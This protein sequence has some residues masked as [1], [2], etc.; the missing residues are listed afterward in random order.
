MRHRPCKNIPATRPPLKLCWVFSSSVAT[1][2]KTRALSSVCYE[3]LASK[4]ALEVAVLVFL[5]ALP[6]S[7]ERV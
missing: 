7:L 3:R 5:I 6:T 1:S 2:H 4:W